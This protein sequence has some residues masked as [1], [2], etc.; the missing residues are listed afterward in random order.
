MPSHLPSIEEIAI[1][2]CDCLLATPSTP[3]W[4][5]SVKSLD[6]HSAGSLELSLLGSDSPCLMQDAKFYNFK[7]LLSLPKMLLSSTCL[8][9]L[10]LTHIDS[11]AAFPADC[12][13]TSLQ[14]LCIHG[15][16]DLAFLP[17]ETWSKYTSLV[18]LELGD[19]CDALTSFPLNGFPVLRRLTIEGC[20]NLESIFILDNAS[21]APSTLQ[22]LQVIHGHALRSFP[23]RM[24]TL[25]ALESLT[26]N[27]L[28]SCCEVA[29]LPPHLQFMH[30]ESLRITTPLTD[31]GL[32]NL[33]ALSDL[34]IEGDDNVNTLLKEKLLPI[35]LVSLTISNLSEMKSFKGNELQ[36]I[37]SMKNLKIQACSRLESFAEDTLPSFLKSLVFEHCPELKSLPFRLPSS[38]E[39]LKFNMCPRLRLFRQYNLPSSLKL[40]SIRRCPMLKAWYETHRRVHVSK[41]AHFPVVK[42]DHEVIPTISGIVVYL[43]LII[44]VLHLRRVNH[45]RLFRLC[46]LRT[47]FTI[48]PP[49][50]STSFPLRYMC[51]FPLSSCALCHST[52]TTNK[53]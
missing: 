19:C 20:M 43:I 2:T 32:Q 5:S 21:L 17:L 36:L 42:I 44:Q 38:L 46:S 35:F 25:I 7:T 48:L 49:F 15:C 40:L 12:L 41:I 24:D 34:H 8:Q 29:C 3:H 10:D 1:I 45:Q 16:G 50:T 14:S 30:T 39:T 27:S 33:I 53:L 31:S 11:L 4:L 37:S 22:S 51:V 23:R 52:S 13:P 18:K 9:H 28:P 26:L 47:P 6:L